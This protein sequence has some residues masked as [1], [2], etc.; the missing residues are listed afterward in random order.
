MNVEEMIAERDI[1]ACRISG[2][3]MHKGELMGAAPTNKKIAFHGIDM[4]RF[5]GGKAVE[6]WH[7]GDDVVVLMQL[8]VKPPM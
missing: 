8:G 4:I 2:T 7:Q 6:V 3:A 5:K 1:V